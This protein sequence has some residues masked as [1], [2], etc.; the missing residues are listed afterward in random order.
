MTTNLK[1]GVTSDMVFAIYGSVAEFGP[2]SAPPQLT[3]KTLKPK[4]EGKALYELFKGAGIRTYP[5]SRDLT[6]VAGDKTY[7]SLSELPERV[8]VVITC[9]GKREASRVVEEAAG[10]GVKHVFFQPR[11]DS[12]AAL[13]LCKAKGM[14]CATGCMLTHWTVT[15][16]KRFVSPCFYMGLGAA[17]LPVK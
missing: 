15:G 11:T 7:R 9:L 1:G 10:A 17:K 16:L 13:E 14:Q 6:K 5:I 4:Y 8:D 12:R 3:S 2:E